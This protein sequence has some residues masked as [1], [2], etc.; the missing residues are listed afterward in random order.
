MLFYDKYNKNVCV[1]VV[2]GHKI[3]INKKKSHITIYIEEYT[4]HSSYSINNNN[5]VAE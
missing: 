1:C 2:K 5:R 3:F 4:L